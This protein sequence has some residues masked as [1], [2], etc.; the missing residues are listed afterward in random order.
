MLKLIK[1]DTFAARVDVSLPTDQPGKNIE[2]DFVARFRYVAYEEYMDLVDGLQAAVSPEDGAPTIRGILAEKRAVL[3]KVLVSVEGI[4][5]SEGNAHPA[6]AQRKLVLDN[7][8][9]IN[10][11]FDAFN[12]HY[13]GADGKNSKRSPKR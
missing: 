9:M 6:D 3:D 11:T 5:D 10:A 13:V 12:K 7:F 8:T 2:G 1:T 4:G